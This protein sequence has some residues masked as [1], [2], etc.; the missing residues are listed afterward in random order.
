MP[1]AV[2][3]ILVPILIA[4]IFRDVVAKKKFSLHYVLL[5][6]LGGVLPDIDIPISMLL[7]TFGIINWNLHKTFTHSIFFPLIVFALFLIFKPFKLNAKVCNIGKHKL[8]LS[9]IFLAIAFGI[10]IHLILDS[11]F[12]SNSFLLYPFS[13]YDFGMDLFSYF[14]YSWNSLAALLDGILLVIWIL[15]L[16]LKHKISDFI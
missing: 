6:G 15:Y 12:G 11:L 16:E 4:A 10:L 2:T 8:N 7:N 1:Y 3:H 13:N 9:Y 14:S 5:A